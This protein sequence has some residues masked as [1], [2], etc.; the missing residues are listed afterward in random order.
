MEDDELF[1][2]LYAI[3]IENKYIWPTMREDMNET[4]KDKREISEVH[5]KPRMFGLR[6]PPS[7]TSTS[8]NCA[9]EIEG[10]TRN[11]GESPRQ[12]KLDP[13]VRKLSLVVSPPNRGE[14]VLGDKE[15]RP[16]RDRPILLEKIQCLMCE[17][18]F[19][20]EHKFHKICSWCK[21]S[22][23]YKSA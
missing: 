7:I 22:N 23:I 8:Y 18:D 19:K 3:C 6:L 2:H 20:P 12:P 5:Q 16:L 10:Q 17:E 1:H 4:I 15:H 13:I 9:K 21:N 11:G 14:K